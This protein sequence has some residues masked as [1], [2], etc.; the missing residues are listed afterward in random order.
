M[1]LFLFEPC[2]DRLF[3][4]KSTRVE[5]AVG[6]VKHLWDYR[7]GHHRGLDKNVAQVFSLFALTNFYKVRHELLASTG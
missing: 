1:G 2:A 7:K 6:I 4:K 3:N 5:H